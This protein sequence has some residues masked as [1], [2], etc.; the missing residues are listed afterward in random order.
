M[1]LSENTQIKLDANT[2]YLINPG[3]IGQ[4]RDKNPAASFIIFDSGKR[5]IQFIRFTYEVKKTQK[6]IREAGL[7]ELLASRLEAGV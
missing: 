3:S 7:P 1:P 6:K 4:P 5:E 2:R